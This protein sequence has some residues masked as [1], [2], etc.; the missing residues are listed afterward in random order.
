LVVTLDEAM[1]DLQNCCEIKRIY[2]WKPGQKIPAIWVV[3]AFDQ[4]IEQIMMVGAKS[5]RGPH[6]LFKVPVK[7]KVKAQ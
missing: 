2:Q 1:F 4:Q 7:T 6:S 5:G 3:G